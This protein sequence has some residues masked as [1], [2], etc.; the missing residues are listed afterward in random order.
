MNRKLFILG[1]IAASLCISG[2]FTSCD[3][4]DDPTPDNGGGTNTFKGNYVIPATAG[5]SEQST[6]YLLTAESLDSGEISAVGSGREF[7]DQI[8][9]WVFYD[10]HYFFGLTYNKGG[11]GTGGCYYLDASN[12]PQK[13]YGYTFQRITTYGKWGHNVITV[14]TGDTQVKD[15]Q[16]NAAQGFLFNYLN[17]TDGSTSTNTKD[18]LAENYL[19]NGERVTMSG[20]VEANGKLYTSIVPTGMSHYGVNTWP[21]CVLNQE[22]V[23]TQKGGQG[24]GAY[25]PGEIPTTQIPDSAFIA[26]YSGDSFDEKPVIARTGK[27]GYASGRNRSQYMQTVWSDDDGNVYAFSG[28]YGRTAT[29]DAST[30]LKRAK[31]TLPSGVVR[32]PKGATNFDDYYCNLETLSGATGHPLYRCWHVGGD[33]FL[34]NNYGCSIDE[35]TSLGTKAPTGEL[36]LFK[37]SEKKLI[38]IT[39]LPDA[40]IISSISDDPYIEGNYFYITV[41][42]TEKDAKPTFYKI[43][44]QTGVAMKG[45]VVN[46]NEVTTVGK[47]ALTQ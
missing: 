29:D 44:P 28:G 6:S 7:E 5:S 43:N 4:S 46:A 36:V 13:K 1:G 27:I 12:T 40:G 31:G 35:V 19:G 34:L 14:S 26:I 16:G 10:Q 15:S 25:T 8:H 20:F 39:G 23:A 18:I 2:I 24:S 21:Q 32:I 41:L 38:A 11:A 37:A 22:Y 30:G 47:V 33:Y 3:S 17:A 42:T 9:F 45:L